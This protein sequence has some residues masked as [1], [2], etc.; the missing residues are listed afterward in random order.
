MGLF[1]GLFGSKK[2]KIVNGRNPGSGWITANRF[3]RARGGHAGGYGAWTFSNIMNAHCTVDDIVDEFGLDKDD[4]EYG[5]DAYLIAY[6]EEYDNAYKEYEDLMGFYMEL[7]ELNESLIAENETE[8]AEL[9]A[10]NEELRE[11]V[12]DLRDDLEYCDD[13]DEA[14]DIMEEIAEL[15]AIITENELRIEVLQE[16]NIRLRDEIIGWYAEMETYS[17]EEF[18]DIDELEKKAR[19]YACEFAQKWY[20]GSEWIPS[21]VLDWGYYTISDHNG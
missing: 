18:M 19:E 16:D 6:Q 5:C 13:P 15:E 4:N 10:E 17:V 21:E 9:E 12:E 8:I 11:E 3:N 2:A 14:M 7:I 20:D 1:S